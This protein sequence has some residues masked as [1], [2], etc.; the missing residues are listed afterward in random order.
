M[1]YQYEVERLAKELLVKALVFNEILVDSVEINKYRTE[2]VCVLVEVEDKTTKDK[3]EYV[4]RVDGETPI[5][6][7]EN[8]VFNTRKNKEWGKERGKM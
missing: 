4:F 6:L 5:L 3:T 7:S 1:V 2:N 8:R